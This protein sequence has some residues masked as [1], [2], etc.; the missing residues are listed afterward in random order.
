[1]SMRAILQS[2]YGTTDVLSVGTTPR[3]T[4]GDGEVIVRVLAAGVDRGTW[5][6]MTGRPYLM[7][8]MGFGFRRPKNPVAGLDLAG[9]VVEVGANV[10]RFKVGDAVFGI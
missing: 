3:P 9:T 7:R 6:F 8:V 5:H 10:T 1:M 4:A 2:A